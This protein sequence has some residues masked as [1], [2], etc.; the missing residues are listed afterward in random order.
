MKN[1]KVVNGKLLQMNKK[2][3]HLKNSQKEWIIH[4]CKQHDLG[5]VLEKIEE[6]EIWIPE[7]EVRKKY[8]EYKKKSAQ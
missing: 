8:N 4:L 7:S 3:C 1:H 6:R 2:W 5:T